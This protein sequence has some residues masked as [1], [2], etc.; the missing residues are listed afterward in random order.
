MDEAELEIWILRRLGAPFLK[1]ELTKS[2]LDDAVEDARK[3]FA[4]KKGAQKQVTIPIVPG[5]TEYQLPDG[6]DTVQ[7]LAMMATSLDL[8]LAFY[9]YTWIDGSPIPYDTFSTP[10]SGGLYSSLVQTLQYVEEAKRILGAE[11]EW[12]QEGRTLYILPPPKNAANA[13]ITAKSSDIV[14][15][16]LSTRDHDLIKR[17][18]LAHAKLDLG[19]VRSKYGSGFPTAQGHEQLDGDTLL[20]E[21]QAEMDVL[22]DEIGLSAMPMMFITG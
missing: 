12:W 9:P 6:V 13:I 17:Y 15:E 18:A 1:I 10:Q 4:A 20:Q 2:H 8:S 16:Q 21:G 19:R 3:W 14:I 5:Q 11:P 22:N 7:N